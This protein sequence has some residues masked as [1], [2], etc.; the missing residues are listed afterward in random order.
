MTPGDE[1]RVRAANL[2]ARAKREVKVTVRAELEGL[3]QS[4]LRLAAQAER[5]SHTDIVY[6][7]VPRARDSGDQE[8]PGDGGP[9]HDPKLNP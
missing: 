4:Y 6:E 8:P 1:Y 5:N 9:D 2:R 3:A 7:W